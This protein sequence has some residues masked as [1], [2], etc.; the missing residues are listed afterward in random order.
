MLVQALVIREKYMNNSKQ[1]FPSITTKFL[2][3][4]DKRPVTSNDEVQHD[5]RKAIAGKPLIILEENGD[6][7]F[8]TN[9][10]RIRTNDASISLYR[11]LLKIFIKKERKKETNDIIYWALQIIRYTH[12]HP[13][14]ILGNVNSHLQRITQFYP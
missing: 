4:I 7:V 13:A 6:G 3:S 9:F 12:P 10:T 5:D 2:R 11:I 1:S 8:L 14:E